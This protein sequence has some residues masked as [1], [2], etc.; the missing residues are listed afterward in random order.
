MPFAK[1]IDVMVVPEIGDAG[2][3][4]EGVVGAGHGNEGGYGSGSA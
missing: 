3:D 2:A 4:F 1:K